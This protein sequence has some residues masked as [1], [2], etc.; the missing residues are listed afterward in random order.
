M[1]HCVYVLR[2]LQCRYERR[3]LTIIWCL[4]R[5]LK[6]VEASLI[7]TYT[8]QIVLPIY[9]IPRMFF[10]CPIKLDC[11]KLAKI[12]LFIGKSSIN[13]LQWF[14][15]ILYDFCIE[16]TKKSTKSNPKLKNFNG[17]SWK[18]IKLRDKEQG[19]NLHLSLHF[20]PWIWQEKEVEY[21]L[22]VEIWFL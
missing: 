18:W 9:P 10:F 7:L 5:R 1:D 15:L 22:I 21:P 12:Y 16:A 2:C 8:N 11:F 19:L 6:M 17:L 14:P 13:Q 20:S 3:C 4:T